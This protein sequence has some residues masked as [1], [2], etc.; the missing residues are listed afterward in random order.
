MFQSFTIAK[1]ELTG[2]FYSPIAYVVLGL[3]ALGTAM[4]FFIY[5]GPG[6]PASIRGTAAAL[7]WLMIFLVPAISMRLV[8]EEFRSGTVETLMTSPVSDAQ[9]IFGKWL[10]AMGFLIVL[11]LPLGVLVG[12]L[13][14]TSRPDWGPILTAMLGLVLTGGLYLAI[15]TFA[16]AMTQNQIIAFLLTVFIICMFTL[17]L[18]FL[19]SAAFVP[20][21]VLPAVY[22]L[23]PMERFSEFNK[24]VL[25][26]VGMV[27]F[28]STS[29]MFL[30]MA[31]K[32]LE[33]KR[34]R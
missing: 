4:I 11:L 10:G 30:F 8:S 12:L 29:A 17:V 16:S 18:Y 23:N 2:L 27:Y 7:L 14:F 25:D 28:V 22:Y 33:S 3:F 34:W 9:V 15:G 24:G 5:Y 20:R 21:A 13:A 26:L 19:S 31:V 1:R 6:S 32:V